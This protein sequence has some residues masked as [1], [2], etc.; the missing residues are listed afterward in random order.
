[1]DKKDLD[2]KTARVMVGGD[3]ITFVA[4]DQYL[5]D[6]RLLWKSVVILAMLD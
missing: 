3:R 5:A 1:M 6:N 2:L 4:T